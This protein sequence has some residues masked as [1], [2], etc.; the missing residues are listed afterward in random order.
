MN[1]PQQ[2]ASFHFD[3][4]TREFHSRQP[5][6]LE[7]GN[8]TRE[9][10]QQLYLKQINRKIYGKVKNGKMSKMEKN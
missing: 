5:S 4:L 7:F 2:N 10:T 9:Y 6:T 8:T 3:L 1:Y